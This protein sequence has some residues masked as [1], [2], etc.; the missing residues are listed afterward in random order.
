MKYIYIFIA[1]VL[2]IG[3]AGCGKEETDQHSSAIPSVPAEGKEKYPTGNVIE[4]KS[5]MEF[6]NIIQKNDI[7]LVQFYADWCGPC[8]YLK[9]II[10]EVAQEFS[11]KVTVVA[12]NVDTLRKLAIKY[13]I[14]SI[15]DV[16]VFK[17]GNPV[18]KF[19]GV[20]PKTSYIQ[21]LKSVL[22]S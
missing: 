13:E 20:Q 17:G 16:K 1:T 2:I 14:S 3:A 7:V 22:S 4:A 18:K 5:E 10:S 19:V 12:V 21:Y 11:G 8:R 15:P 9:P 6:S